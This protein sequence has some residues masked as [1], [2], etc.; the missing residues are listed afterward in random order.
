MGGMIVMQHPG[1]N[2]TL[3]SKFFSRPLNA[4]TGNLIPESVATKFL[5]Y[6]ESVQKRER[7]N[8]NV[9]LNVAKA[10]SSHPNQTIISGALHNDAARAEFG[11][12]KNRQVRINLKLSGQIA[13]EF[14]DQF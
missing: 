12:R 10:D 11:S 1:F 9:K 2:H 14:G 13:I 7:Q 3:L 6:F 8:F 5:L 4:P